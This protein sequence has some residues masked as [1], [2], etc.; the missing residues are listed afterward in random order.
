MRAESHVLVQ[1]MELQLHELPS[2]AF[3]I[4]AELKC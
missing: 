2:A 4:E 1:L 3:G